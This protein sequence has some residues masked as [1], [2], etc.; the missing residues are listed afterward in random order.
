MALAVQLQERNSNQA[1]NLYS[2]SQSLT[3]YIN[4]GCHYDSIGDEKLEATAK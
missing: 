2:I 3:G 4:Y 1:L